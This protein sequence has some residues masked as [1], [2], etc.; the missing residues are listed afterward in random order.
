MRFSTHP[1]VRQAT[2]KVLEM[3]EQGILDPAAIV[4][5]CLSYMSESDVADMAQ[6]VGW[7]EEEEEADED[8]E[9]D[10]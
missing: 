8:E 10:D 6:R 2:C 1:N 5:E 3:M 7:F 4:R 9:S